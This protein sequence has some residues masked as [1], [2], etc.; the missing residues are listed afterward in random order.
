M[1]APPLCQCCTSD[2]RSGA[3]LRSTS[4][5]IGSVVSTTIQRACMRSKTAAGVGSAKENVTCRPVASRLAVMPSTGDTSSGLAASSSACAAG[6]GPAAA[7]EAS[8]SSAAVSTR[9]SLVSSGATTAS[10]DADASFGA[11]SAV[12]ASEAGAGAGASALT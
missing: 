4:V 11:L 9:G 12:S 8:A 3:T 6:G 2:M 10:S 5:S 7:P 1:V